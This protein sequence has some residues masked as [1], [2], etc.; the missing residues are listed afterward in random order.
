[1]CLCLYTLSTDF[2]ALV[3]S[4]LT[5]G[6]SSCVL[7]CHI[8]SHS[9]NTRNTY[10]LGSTCM[11]VDFSPSL[12]GH[13]Q[14]KCS[15]GQAQDIQLNAYRIKRSLG[16][17]YSVHFDVNVCLSSLLLG[18]L[19]PPQSW[20]H[21]L[22]PV[23]TLSL[24]ILPSLTPLSLPLLMCPWTI[25]NLMFPNTMPLMFP[26]IHQSLKFYCLVPPMCPWI[27]WSWTFLDLTTLLI[28]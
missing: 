26:W 13:S 25:Q 27:P 6:L 9:S 8:T 21:L 15:Q 11:Q 12:L 5:A 10:C 19:L 14:S 23:T 28:P 3:C 16:C 17:I 2:L 22:P 7:L 20:M 24:W 18:N 1:M 4:S